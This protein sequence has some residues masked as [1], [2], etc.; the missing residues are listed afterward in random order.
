MK[1]RDDFPGWFR[2]SD[3]TEDDG[4]M[5]FVIVVSGFVVFVSV[6]VYFL[7]TYFF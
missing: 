4:D 6:I 2:K 7:L 1:G 3:G 5:V